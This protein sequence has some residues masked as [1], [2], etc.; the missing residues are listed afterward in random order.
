M[1]GV[2]VDP[3][4]YQKWLQSQRDFFAKW[5]SLLQVFLTLQPEDMLSSHVPDM[6]IF[7]TAFDDRLQED[8][9]PYHFSGFT[10]FSIEWTYT[11]DIDQEVFSIDN[12]AH[13][14]LKN[15]PKMDGWIQALFHDSQ[16]NRFLLPHLVPVESVA[17]LA[18]DPPSSAN[19]TPYE[20]LQT[21]LVKPK[22]LDHISPSHLTGQR[23]Q[24]MLFDFIQSSQQRDLSATL[25]TWQAQ[26]LPFRELVFFILCLAIGGKYLALVDQRCVKDPYGEGLYLGMMADNDL[27]DYDELATSLGVG[28]HMDGLPMGS[29][30]QE[31]KYWLEGALICLIP[32]LNYP[33]ILEKA[34]VDAIEYGRADCTNESF[35]AVLI[36]IEHLVLIRSLPDGR[37]DRTEIL[38]L[39]PIHVHV[40]KDSR[41]RY[42]DQALDIFYNAMF[43]QNSREDDNCEERDVEQLSQHSEQQDYK[44]NNDRDD[45]K[46][47]IQR[48]ARSQGGD[49][50]E[51]YGRRSRGSEGGS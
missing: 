23:L 30:P 36:S 13:F 48:G 22:S 4:K 18:L 27:E 32:Q 47:R 49:Q 43:T 42:G 44:N 11:I 34:I 10:N 39:I 40:S 35:N 38:P 50:G 12:G 14:R 5:D 8:A 31:T 28:Y 19:S 6:S 33:G 29:A 9:P 46:K 21:R 3:E 20:T 26:D 16:G 41:A 17:T 1:D 37:I 45:K 7:H 2:P 51:E 25:L 15:M 24:W